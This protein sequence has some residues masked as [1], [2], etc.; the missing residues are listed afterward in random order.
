MKT[1]RECV[2]EVLTK[3]G[4]LEYFDVADTKNPQS[5]FTNLNEGYFVI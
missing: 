1:Y 5:F 4:L 3:H 2:I